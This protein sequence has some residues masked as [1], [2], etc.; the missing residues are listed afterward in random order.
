MMTQA[1]VQPVEDGAVLRQ[2]GKALHLEILE[3][4]NVKVSV[5]SLDPPP[6]AIDKTIEGLKRIEITIPAYVYEGM[7][8]A[9]K[10]RLSMKNEN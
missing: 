4:Q 10:V 1:D 5:I 3:P 2:D 7:S 8:G 9:V 6:M